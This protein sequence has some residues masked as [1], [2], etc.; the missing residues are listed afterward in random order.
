[1]G[2]Q[3]FIKGG[4]HHHPRG[5]F[6]ENLASGLAH[7]MD[8]ELDSEAITAK[9]GVLQGLDPR[10]KLLAL[11]AL[12]IAVLL[13]TTLTALAALFLLAVGLAFLSNVTLGRLL[14]QVWISVLL[15][16]G[17]IALPSIVLVPGDPV[18][19]L[20][21]V[22]WTV[23]LQGLRS[24]AFLIGRAETA[25]T[26]ALLLILT[27]PWPHVLKALRAIKIP[28]VAV[29][30]LGMTYRYIFVLMQTA[31]NMFEARRA[32]VVGPMTGAERRRMIVTGAGVLLS[33]AITLSEEV[34]LAMLAR[35]YHGEVYLLDDF[36]SR[37]RDWAVLVAALAVP[38]AIL[39][40]QR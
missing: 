35:G 37:P 24:A 27:T 20:P 11:L 25:A 18:F 26:F 36:R 34:Y 16:T 33:K 6:L 1:M 4:H 15:F 2:E 12:I 7:A 8:H 21:L 14:K 40:V 5:R 13:V 38:A 39:W 32:R 23:T 3:S 10:F 9:H 19:E 22:H 30:V 17:V 28:V 31:I 29:A